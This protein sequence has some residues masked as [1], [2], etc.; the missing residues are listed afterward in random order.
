[1][2]ASDVAYGGGEREELPARDWARVVVDARGTVT[3]WSAAAERLL[4]YPADEV[5]GA[6]AA[7]LLA[8]AR[9]AGAAAEPEDTEHPGTVPASGRI[10]LR[11]RDG[12]P[13]SCLLAVR[14]EADDG[15]AARWAVLLGPRDRTDPEADRALLEVLF[16]KSPVGLVV[17]DPELRLLRF[18]PAAEGMQGAPAAEALGRR[19]TEVWPDLVAEQAERVMGKVLESG[20]PVIGFEK[21]G[22]PPGDP[23]HEHVYSASAFRLEDADGRILGVADVAVDVTDRHRAQERLSL[24]A[25]G[26]ARIGTT[27]DVVRTAQELADVVVPGLTD[28][29]AV[30]VL[31]PVLLGG[32]IEPGPVGPGAVLR[33]AASRSHGTDLPPGAY[34]VGEVGTFPF[35]APSSEALSDLRPRLVSRVRDDSDWVLRDPVRGRRI[36]EEKIHSLMLVPLVVHDLVLGVVTFYR[37]GPRDPFQQ[38]DLTLATGLVRRAAV[39]LDNARRYVR[40]HNSLLALRRSLLPHELPEHKG[41]EVAHEYVHAGSGGDWVDV[42]PLSGAR[43]ALVAG[44][45]SGHG[46][47]AAAM[48]GRLHAAVHTLSDL[49]LE[50]D[51]LLARL[52][53]LVFR[54]AG[55]DSRAGT[56]SPEG[57]E[58]AD[59]GSPEVDSGPHRVDA[60]GST[61]L[62]L[63]YDPVSRHCTMAGAGHPGPVVSSPDGTVAA[64]DLPASEPLGRPGQQFG[65][66]ELDLP[67]DALVTLYT[68]GLLQAHEGGAGRAVL[69]SL[70]CRL[71]GSVRE[72]CRVLT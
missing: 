47:G 37:W 21:R 12:R 52:D 6:S 9:D 22:R 34:E 17:L 20:E 26:G 48:M 14:P 61:C 25:E 27:L 8:T 35:A 58:R 62:Y 39:C 13:V 29:V 64:F 53:D 3:E 65:K 55:A 66:A 31:E 41:V 4:G 56:N 19:P 60:T 32:E 72:I 23:G 18:N 70:V 7:A 68:P 51:E 1:M 42:I 5:V 38:D 71:P 43:V 69:E 63:I 24:L 50:P 57:S 30:E 10:L 16:T 15:T 59:N 45:S 11:H 46:M 36:L 28:G 67:E 40:E 33:R 2:G 49:G 54:L 44:S